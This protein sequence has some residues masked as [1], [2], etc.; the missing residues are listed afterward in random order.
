LIGKAIVEGALHSDTYWPWAQIRGKYGPHG[1]PVEAV[2]LDSFFI[3]YVLQW[4]QQ[5][6]NGIA[7][8]GYRA[9][10]AALRAAGVPVYGREDNFP[11]GPDHKINVKGSFAA[12]MKSHGTGKNLQWNH[13]EN[14]IA[15]CP[16]GSPSNAALLDQTIGRTHRTDQKSPRVSAEVVLHTDELREAWGQAIRRAQYMQGTTGASSKLLL[17]LGLSATSEAA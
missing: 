8:Y 1:P 11:I 15:N 14:L 7:W 10:G 9:V 4:M 13:W 3:R 5:H 16:A 12:S 2:W 6:P 17:G